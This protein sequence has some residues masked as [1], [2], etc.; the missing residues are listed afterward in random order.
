MKEQDAYN[1]NSNNDVIKLVP[2]NAQHQDE[3]E[4]AKNEMNNDNFN[5]NRG[6]FGMSPKEI[7]EIIYKYDVRN[8]IEEIEV[9]ESMGGNK[10]LEKVFKTDLENGLKN[11]KLD[12]QERLD[13]YGS[14]AFEQEPLPHCCEYVWEALGDLMIRILIVAAI[15]QIGLGASPLSEHPDKDWIEGLSITMA[16]FVVVCVGSLTNYTKEKKFKELND[17]NSSMVKVTIKRNGEA[18]EMSPDDVLVGDLIKINTGS[19]VAADG[20]LISTEGQ[21]KIEESSLTGESDLI[22]KDTIDVCLVKCKEFIGKETNRHSVPSP[23]I[24]SGTQVKEG[25]GWYLAWAVGTNSKKGQIM[26]SVQQNQENDDS[27]T[28][29]ELKLDDIAEDI[30]W[31]GIAAGVCT[32]VALFI[33]FGITYASALK[34]YNEEIKNPIEGESLPS[35][36]KQGISKDVLKIILLCIAIIVVAIPEGLPLAVTLSLAFSINKMMTDNNL[37]RRMHACET[38][39]GANFICTDKTG[40]LTANIMN[41]FK[42]YDGQQTLDLKEVSEATKIHKDPMN[43]FSRNYFDMLVTSVVS[44]LQ[45]TI[46]EKDDI[47]EPSKTDLAFANLFHN[48]DVKL[49]P[50]QS[51]YKVNKHDV[52]RIPFSSQRKKMTTIVSHPDFPTG[53][54]AFMKGASEI[55]MKSV[56]YIADSK[57]LQTTTKSDEDNEKI[58]EIIKSYA[59]ESLR[60]ICVAYKDITPIEAETYL[61]KDDCGNNIVE[62]TGF[63]LICI[64]GIKDTLRNRVPE[65]IAECHNA[66]ITVIMVTGDLKETAI[67]ISKECGIWNLTE[68]ENI[69]D[70][71]SLTGE[72]FFK[73]IGGLECEIC[74]L[75]VKDCLCPK[76]KKE[77]ELKKIDI[78]KVQKQKVKNMKE[79]ELIVKQLKVLARSRP[80]DKFALVLGLRRLDYVVAVTGDG[81]NDA[82]ALSKSDVGFAMGIEGTDV[83]KDA[84][85]IIILDDNFAS[86]VKAVVWGRNI[87]DCIRK[88]I[89][90]QL[91]VNL[92]ACVLV[93]ITACIGNETPITA[94]QMLWLN[95]IMDSLGSLALATEPP[96]DEILKRKPNSKREYIIN[97]RM[98]KH[99]MGHSIIL[100][101][102]LIILYLKGSD[103]LIEQYPERIANAN[104]IFNCYGVFPGRAPENGVYYVLSGSQNSWPT[105]TRRIH[106]KTTV[107]CGDYFKSTDLA[108]AFS[109]YKSTYGSTS[110]MTILFNVFVLYTLLNQVNA[111]VINDEFNVFYNIHK[112]LYFITLVILEFILQAIL[113][114]F[115]SIAFQTSMDGLTKEQWGYSIGFALV[116]YPVSIILKILKLEI[117]I[118]STF[119]CVQKMFRSKKVES[120]PD[121][122]VK[123]QEKIDS[124]NNNNNIENNLN[125]HINDNIQVKEQSYNKPIQRQMSKENSAQRRRSLL[126]NINPHY[127]LQNKQSSKMR[128]NKEDL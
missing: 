97:Y 88:F 17:R 58:K 67:A 56:T 34:Q 40:T 39:G 41:V 26:Q 78:E 90:F 33:R 59:N 92:T 1:G 45:M 15:V 25:S 103:F 79:F 111:R 85:D 8:F 53:Y 105:S 30:G 42:L 54:R 10:G 21:I 35:D 20:V 87:Y 19:I 98:W 50:I 43:Y 2:Q 37:V 75:S 18:L 102:I 6:T 4:D 62:N 120:D 28:P 115:G 71:Y 5:D 110:H 113:I 11:D 106:G 69:P 114:Q 89:T 29:L 13:I 38:M 118:E 48:F 117:C 93:F 36:P 73:R 9:L 23:L 126:E 119:K 127:L 16:V 51:K 12:H 70:D 81:T 66:H 60:T 63:T 55:I 123:S 107:E 121:S 57:T 124:V 52:R 95:M 74:N 100:F 49:F 112:N 99:I 46:T 101:I 27:K 7:Q 3:E 91:T 65:A 61:I 31:F 64:V 109:K 77:A 32:L 104:I 83:A 76:T 22:E 108:M 47:L 68:N 44:N 82:Q 80:L 122:D 14:N 86:I 116:C 125:S 84:A 96:H 94:I 128:S 72:E 24:F